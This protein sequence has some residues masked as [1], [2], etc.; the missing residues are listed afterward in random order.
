MEALFAVPGVGKAAKLAKIGIKVTKAGFKVAKSKLKKAAK[1][2]KKKLDDTADSVA[3]AVGGPKPAMAGAGNG[4][5]VPTSSKPNIVESR[6]AGSGG[7]GAKPPSRPSGGKPELKPGQLVKD[8]KK[9][10]KKVGKGPKGEVYQV[11]KKATGAMEKYRGKY[12]SKDTAKHA[13]GNKDGGSQMKVYEKKGDSYRVDYS[14]DKNGNPM[15]GKH[16]SKTDWFKL[17]K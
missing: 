15:S 8:M 9:Q 13:S 14:V 4:G 1:A 5:R 12:V 7:G 3:D 10:S 16:E 2:A 6:A 17:K 11:D